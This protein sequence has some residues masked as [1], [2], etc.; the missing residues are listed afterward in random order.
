MAITNLQE[1]NESVSKYLKKLNY[2]DFLFFSNNQFNNDSYNLPRL[3]NSCYAIKLKIILDEWKDI[4]DNIKIKWINFL[5]SFQIHEYE[6]FNTYFVDE[7]IY[8]YHFESASKVKDIA[9]T[10]VNKFANRNYKKSSLKLFE[11]INAESKQALSTIFDSGFKNKILIQS[12]FKN[13]YEVTDY[14][15]NLNWKYPWNAGGQ[16]ASLC[17]FSETQSYGYNQTLEEFIEKYLD[18]DTGAYFRGIPDSPREI[19][20]GSMKVISGLE[21]LNV[22]IHKP[23]KLIDFCLLNKP[24]AE[25]CDIVDY[26]YVLFSCSSQTNY[27]K[28]EIA[29]LFGEIL[30]L[31]VDK[32]FIKEEGAFSYFFNKSQTHY[33]GY[34]VSQGGKHADIHGTLL[35]MWAISMIQNLKDEDSKLKLIKP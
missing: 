25:G 19:I 13:N 24:E 1:V 34:P 30:D 5:S 4:N 31:I 12:R 29:I 35:S 26:I 22:K 7:V 15:S 18:Y 20:N 27:K 21:W 32:L 6:I 16:F 10:L 33:Y 9:K 14:L 3:G 28:N 11:S 8:N 17:L 23:E 2:D